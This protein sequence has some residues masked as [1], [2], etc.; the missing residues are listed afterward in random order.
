MATLLK[1]GTRASPLAMAQ[2][3]EV[4]RRLLAAHP[5]LEADAIELVSM[6][7]EGDRILDRTLAAAGGKG[8]FTKELEVALHEGAVDLV[9]HSSKDMPTTLPDG[10]VLPVFLPREDIRDAF[11]SETY[12]SLDNMP[13]GSLMGT[14]SLRRQALTLRARPD[15]KV[16]PFRGNVQTRLKKLKAKEADATYLAYAGLRRLDLDHVA[17][18]VLPVE[19]FPPAPA[20]GAIA[21]EIRDGDERV[22]ALVGA[23]NHQDTK[24]RVVAERAFLAALDGSCRTPIAAHTNL[25]G[26]ELSFYGVILSIDGQQVF[27]RSGTAKR[28]EG[29]DL[30][31]RL[32]A[33]IKAEA[34]PAFFEA[35]AADIAS[36]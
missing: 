35:L 31:H 21:I 28:G 4:K 2:A 23:L 15:L 5:G 13:S 17:K 20:Q 10:L 9:V 7:T 36:Q 25:T 27:E 34:G 18:T 1:I 22:A 30:G 11:I 16:A 6:T 8:L 33:E 29:V 32:G 19:A 26:D 24:D 12:D 3:H 14:A